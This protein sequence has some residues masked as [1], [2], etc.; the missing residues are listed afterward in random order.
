[1]KNVDGGRL[2]IF[3]RQAS[4]D[5]AVPRLWLGLLA[6]AHEPRILRDTSQAWSTPSDRNTKAT[7]T[8]SVLCQ[9]KHHQNESQQVSPLLPVL[10]GL[11]RATP[12]T[13]QL[14]GFSSW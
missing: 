7:S 1:M 9:V 10:A 4:P 12:K 6:A 2:P 8:D 5:S 14:D 13:H 11:L 3:W